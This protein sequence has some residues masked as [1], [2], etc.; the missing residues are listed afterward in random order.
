ME[1]IL[2]ICRKSGVTHNFHVHLKYHVKLRASTAYNYNSICEKVYTENPDAL[3]DVEIANKYLQGLVEKKNGATNVYY[4]AL[5]KWY[6][7]YFQKKKV[8]D[9]HKELIKPNVSF[10][11]LTP[12]YL[13][14]DK[15]KKRLKQVEPIQYRLCAL[16]MLYGGARV[17][18]ILSIQF[19]NILIDEDGIEIVVEKSKTDG[20]R[21]YFTESNYV[22]D[23]LI[24]FLIEN[25]FEEDDYIFCKDTK[26]YSNSDDKTYIETN[27][28]YFSKELKKKTNLRTHDLKRNL[29]KALYDNNVEVTK[30]KKLL[31]HK[32][33]DTTEIYLEDITTKQASYELEKI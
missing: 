11:K 24:N 10:K 3:F 21:I 8:R 7:Y 2:P 33:L 23:P 17:S 12:N 19:K 27:R 13:P 4:Y 16:V 5:K 9:K 20:Y 18:E 6:Q 28:K 1:S 25:E 32:R 26:R 14:L 31:H 15:L 30:I 22:Y 29:A